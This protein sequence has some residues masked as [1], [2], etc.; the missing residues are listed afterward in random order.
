MNDNRHDGERSAGPLDAFP[1]DLGFL[2]MEDLPIVRGLQQLG[3]LGAADSPL[4]PDLRA[5]LV[6]Q[7]AALSANGRKLVAMPA[8]G[9]DDH[10]AQPYPPAQLRSRQRARWLR[11]RVASVAAAAVVAVGG[12]A[13]WQHAG[14]PA[15]VS[16]QVI[17]RHA[18]AALPPA[19]E[20]GIIHQIRTSAT[21]GIMGLPAVRRETWTQMGAD[22]SLAR[23]AIVESTLSGT[24]MLRTVQDGLRFRNYDAVLGVV[25]DRTLTPAEAR[26]MDQGSLQ[27]SPSAAVGALGPARPVAGRATAAGTPRS[28]ARR[29][30]W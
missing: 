13:T 15:V 17:L 29:S 23:Q 9:H 19:T 25:E 21:K 7:A 30:M 5:Q 8:V 28:T 12:L 16:A 6:R 24:L 14:S 20:P 4:R 22:G 11:S 10:D 3:R 27:R 1:R 2:D 26:Q 18:V